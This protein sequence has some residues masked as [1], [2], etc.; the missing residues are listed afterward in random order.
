MPISKLPYKGS[1]AVIGG[2][3]SGLS[4][5]YFLNKLRPDINIEIYERNSR[6][7]GWIKSEKVKLGENDVV[8]EKGPRTLR[9]VSDGTLLITDILRSLGMKDSLEGIL[10]TSIANRKYILND[11]KE[12]VQV[13]NSL[14]TFIDFF[15]SGILNGAVRGIGQEPFNRSKLGKDEDE[16]IESF[17]KRRFKSTTLTDNILSAVIHGIYAGSVSD[18][19]VRAIMPRLV[20]MEA[21][22]GS[23]VKEIIKRIK[24]PSPEYILPESLRQYELKISKRKELLQIRTDLKKFPMIKLKEGL[25][26]FPD[27][28]VE[29]LSNKERVNIFLNS[30][31]SA[32]DHQNGL[33]LNG[34][35]QKAY[36]HIHSTI[37]PTQ[38]GKI[39]KNEYLAKLLPLKNVSISLVNVY[40]PTE[41]LIPPG[42]HGF[43]FL[44]PKSVYNPECL[45]GTI[46]DSD[47][48]QN[49]ISIYNKKLQNKENYS[50][51]T[52][53]M[54]GHFYDKSGIPSPGIVFK[55]VRH[56]L[57]EILQV[58]TEAYNLKVHNP[59]N[60]GS[61][62]HSSKNDIIMS[63]TFVPEC[64]PQYTL[65]YLSKK[66][67][68]DK[69]LSSDGGMSL[70]GMAYGYG[71][72]VPDCVL[73][74]L[75]T[76]LKLA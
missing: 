11:Q 17:M 51:I 55:A 20:E 30:R 36:L 50:K 3:I 25:Q 71:V 74:S 42:K 8:F 2:G 12:L 76:A 22:S 40:V 27:A 34:L 29:Y 61:T 53:M 26:A 63:Y 35:E 13:P 60:H 9:G 33:I 10:L 7:G 59:K 6:C 19:S 43:G 44:V 4:F 67:K 18:L 1:V 47:I 52:L 31:I 69:F 66:E 16:S 14:K 72:G 58:D 56:I 5:S 24:S 21:N 65:D 32:I 54:G 62:L 23:L 28:L 48:E 45:L 49:S 37:N 64:I 15:K 73:N 39:V 57:K 70:G 38:L 68:I 41:L 46:F 75:D